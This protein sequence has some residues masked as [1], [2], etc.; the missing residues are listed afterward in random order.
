MYQYEHM[1]EITGVKTS[2][3]PVAQDMIW[4]TV[5]PRQ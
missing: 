5:L 2:Y 1:E 3:H 4:N